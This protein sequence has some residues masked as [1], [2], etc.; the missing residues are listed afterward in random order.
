MAN[1]LK[2]A[3]CC[4]FWQEE[5]ENHPYCHWEAR[6]PDDQAPCEYED[7][8]EEE[9]DEPDYP[10]ETG[11]MMCDAHGVCAGTDCPKYHECTWR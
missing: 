8:Y 9:W 2:C 6:C 4:Y 5:N 1:T 10:D 3:E 7:D 11:N